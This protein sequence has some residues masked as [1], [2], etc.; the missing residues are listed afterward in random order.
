[1]S[2]SVAFFVTRNSVV[3]WEKSKTSNQQTTHRTIV[4]AFQLKPKFTSY[5]TMAKKLTFLLKEKKHEL[6]I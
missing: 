5:S 6:S 2:P 3:I 4:L 1:M